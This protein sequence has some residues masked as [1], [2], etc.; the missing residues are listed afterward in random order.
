MR[1]RSPVGGS[2][3]ASCRRIQLYDVSDRL[4]VISQVLSAMSTK[5]K[6]RRYSPQNRHFQQ[7]AVN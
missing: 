2:A 4:A 1:A 7:K 3:D 5:L 6:T